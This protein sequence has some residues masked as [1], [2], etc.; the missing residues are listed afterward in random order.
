MV[1]CKW[2]ILKQIWSES[3]DGRIIPKDY[4]WCK[5]HDMYVEKEECQKCGLNSFHTK[6]TP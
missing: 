3:C 2:S 1:K 5:F 6:K 4:D